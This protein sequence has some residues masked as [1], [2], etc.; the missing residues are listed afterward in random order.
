MEV[1]HEPVFRPKCIDQVEVSFDGIDRGE[2]QSLKTRYLPQDRFDQGS[3]PGLARQISAVAGDVDACQHD[4]GMAGFN[5]ALNLPDDACYRHRPGIAS[6]ERNDAERAAMIAAVLHLHEGP[7]MF[8]DT[9]EQG[10]T[11]RA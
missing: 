9:V 2:P 1:R 8:F 3:G 4:L 11:E 10:C 5:Q 7:G 6:S